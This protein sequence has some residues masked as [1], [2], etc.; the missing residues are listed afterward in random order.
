MAVGS[1]PL[2]A[3][4]RH[5]LALDAGSQCMPKKEGSSKDREDAVIMADTI[6]TNLDKKLQEFGVDR[7]WD[8]IN[9][10]RRS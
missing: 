2:G 4:A 3:T 8:I 1:G 7:F 10:G 5:L 6:L 9:F